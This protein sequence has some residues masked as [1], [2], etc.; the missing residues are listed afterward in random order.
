GGRRRAIA[1]ADFHR[2]PGD[3]PDIETVRERGEFITAVLLPP[4]IGGK[5]IYRKVRDRASYALALVSVGVVIQPEGTGR[6]AVGGVAHKPGR[7]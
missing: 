4:P 3:T 7:I 2:L 6:V 5:H 1:I